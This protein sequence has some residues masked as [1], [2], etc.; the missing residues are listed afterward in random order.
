MA[1]ALSFPSRM[2]LFRLLSQRVFSLTQDSPMTVDF[3]QYLDN[4]VLLPVAAMDSDVKSAI[5]G[6]VRPVRSV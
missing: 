6:A 4:T 3:F 5:A 2:P 1:D